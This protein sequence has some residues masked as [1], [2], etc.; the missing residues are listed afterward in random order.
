MVAI[1]NT[2][3]ENLTFPD[4]SEDIEFR[5]SQIRQGEIFDHGRLFVNI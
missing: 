4:D 5:F 1:F 3:E 2:G